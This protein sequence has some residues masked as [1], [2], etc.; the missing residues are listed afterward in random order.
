M[1]TALYTQ[2]SST[3]NKTTFTSIKDY[4]RESEIA[5]NS[6]FLKFISANRK[7]ISY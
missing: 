5:R 7:W 1:N 2:L 6:L 4:I 3:H